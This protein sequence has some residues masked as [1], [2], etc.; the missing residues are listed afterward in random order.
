MYKYNLIV[1]NKSLIEFCNRLYDV[2]YITVDTEFVR[3]RTYWPQLCL[4]QVAGPN[5][6][7]AIDPLAPGINLT[8]LYDLMAND[9]IL[10]VFHS[11]RQD[12]EIFFHHTGGNIPTPLFDTQ[13]AAMVC[14]FNHTVSYETLVSQLINVKI[15]KSLRLTNWLARPLTDRQLNYA[16]ADVIHLRPVYEELKKR[17]DQ[18]CRSNWLCDEM[19]K[20]TDPKTYLC[21]P[22]DA[23][24]KLKSRSLNSRNLIILKEVTAWRE[25]TAQEKNIPRQHVLRDEMIIRIANCIPNSIKEFERISCD[26]ATKQILLKIVVCALNTPESTWPQPTKHNDLPSDL[27]IDLL[28]I[29]L[30]LKC[31]QYD[32]APVL[33]ASSKD[34]EAIAIDG[35]NAK[36]PA[37]HDDWRRSIFGEDALCFKRGEIGITMNKNELQIINFKRL[38]NV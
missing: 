22:D 38:D 10:K 3:E 18:N 1:D 15:D 29:L 24:L 23:W 31:D 17:L 16:L 7:Q 32:V 28:K 30:K 6:V 33:I 26:F 12:I 9:R 5:E 19:T 8:P 27:I 4:V 2:S 34:L 37:L 11:A 36:V 14:G 25:R 20:L 13:V 35:E 21:I